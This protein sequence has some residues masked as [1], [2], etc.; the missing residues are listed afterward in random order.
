MLDN[1]R[2]VETLPADDNDRL[3]PTRLSV[4]DS[5]IKFIKDNIERMQE[6]LRGKEFDRGAL[7]KRA[8]ELNITTDKEWKIVEIPI[9]PDKHVDVEYLKTHYKEKYDLILKI[10]ESRLADK[11]K[12]ETEK[13]M[14][15][16]IQ[17]DVKAIIRDKVTL[18][19]VI[20][21]QQVPSKY[22]YSVV[23]R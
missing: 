10:A 7:I 23:K 6:Q 5:D 1:I 17:S 2:E 22:E 14:G 12:K 4:I 9:Y 19:L 3:I 20:P 13:S 16:I 18:S 21:P 8:K 15:N 11:I